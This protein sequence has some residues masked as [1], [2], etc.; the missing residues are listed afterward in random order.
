M[1]DREAEYSVVAFGSIECG[2]ASN[3]NGLSGHRE[4]VEHPPCVPP[5]V[6][7]GRFER[8]LST[9]LHLRR[10]KTECHRQ[11]VF[12]LLR[13]LACDQPVADRLHEGFPKPGID[14]PTLE[15]AADLRASTPV[16]NPPT[17][18]ECE[19]DG[20]RNRMGIISLY[21][22]NQ[23]IQILLVVLRGWLCEPT[24]HGRGPSL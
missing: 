18:R 14:V 5:D 11:L 17:L 6:P 24:F 16:P 13:E 23:D 7:L 9:L 19:R 2:S 3:V 20:L 8:F 15:I 12:E 4:L 22:R 21:P 1:G 10:A